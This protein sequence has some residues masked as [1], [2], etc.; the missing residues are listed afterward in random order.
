MKN[1]CRPVLLPLFGL[2]TALGALSAADIEIDADA[3]VLRIDGVDAGGDFRGTPYIATT[4]NGLTRFLFA[5]DLVFEPDDVVTGTGSFALSLT[6]SGD[7]VIPAGAEIDVSALPDRPGPGGGSGGTYGMGG[8]GGTGGSGGS[9]GAGGTGGGGGTSGWTPGQPQAGGDGNLGNNG[10][11]GAS[12]KPGE[13]GAGGRDGFNA[14]HSG[15][16][17]NF[18]D[19][20]NNGGSGGTSITSHTGRGGAR[21]VSRFA[22]PDPGGAG[23]SGWVFFT[24]GDGSDAV[25][26]GW[27]PGGSGGTVRRAVPELTGGGGGAGGQGGSGGAGGGGAGGGASGGGGGGG[28]ADCCTNGTRGTNGQA[29]GNGGKGGNGGSGGRGGLGGSGGGALEIHALGKMTVGGWLGARGGAGEVPQSGGA[30]AGGSTVSYTSATQPNSGSGGFRGGNGGSGA[31][32]GTGGSGGRGGR[33]GAGGGGAGGTIL[34]AATIMDTAGATVDVSGGPAGATG[35]WGS[36]GESGRLV[37]LSETAFSGSLESTMDPEPFPARGDFNPHLSLQS[38]TP[39]LPVFVGGAAIAGLVNGVNLGNFSDVLAEAPA[40]ARMALVRRSAGQGMD[41]PT[42]PHHEFIFLINLTGEA[43]PKPHFGI[44]VPGYLSPLVDGGLLRNPAFGGNGPVVRGELPPYGVYA[45]LVP[46]AD[47]D[48]ETYFTLGYIPEGTLVSFTGE[49]P[50][51]EGTLYLSHGTTSALGEIP[52]AEVVPT[53][54]PSLPAGAGPVVNFDLHGSLQVELEPGVDEDHPDYLLLKNELLAA[55]AGWSLVGVSPVYPSGFTATRLETGLRRITFTRVPGWLPP[56]DRDIAIGPALDPVETR[57]FR[58]TKAPAYEIGSMAPQPVYPGRTLGFWLPAGSTATIVEGNAA[59]A[60]VMLP[61]GWF[62]YDPAATDRQ[63]FSVEFSGPGGTQTVKI[64][65]LKDIPAEQTIIALQPSGA[66]PPDPAGRDFTLLHE[67]AGATSV[68]F[69]PVN[70]TRRVTI[71]G[72]KVVFSSSGDTRLY[73]AVHARDNVEALNIYADEVVIEDPLELRQTEV[74]IFARVL[75][76]KDTG[77]GTAALITTPRQHTAGDGG[78]PLPGGDV[79]LFVPTIVSDPTGSARIDTSGGNT[80]TSQT[81][82]D[83]GLIRSFFAGEMA[84]FAA[85]GGGT[86]NGSPGSARTPETLDTESMPPAYAWLHPMGVRQTILYARNLYYLGFMSEAT[87]LLR[88]YDGYLLKLAEFPEPTLLPDADHPRLQF[89][90]LHRDLAGL[91]TRLDNKLDYFGNSAGWV[92]LLSFEANFQL[93]ESAIGRAMRTLYLHHWLSNSGDFLTGKIDALRTARKEMGAENDRLRNEWPL[94]KEEID[95]LGIEADALELRINSLHDDLRAIE[96]RLEQK[97]AEIIEDRDNI[98][99]WKK[100][101]RTAAALSQTIPA[102]QPALGVAGS[103]LDLASRVDEQDPLDTVLEGTIIAIQFKAAQYQMAAA[104][105][106]DEINASTKSEEELDRDELFDKA[107]QLN[108]TAVAVDESSRTLRQ[109]FASNEAPEDE[110]DSEIAKLRAADPQLRKIAGEL[111]DILQ[112]KQLFAARII[113]LEERLLEIPSIIQKNRLAM[114]QIETSIDDGNGILDPQAFAVV[115]EASARAKDRLRRY[116]YQLAKSFEYRLLKPYRAEGDQAYDPVSVF[117]KI[118]DILEAAEAGGT[119]DVQAGQPHVLSATGFQ[120]L[121]A[122]FEEELAKLVDRIVDEYESGAGVEQVSPNLQINLSGRQLEGLHSDSG[123]RL[124]LHRDLFLQ[125]DNEAQRIADLRVKS[126]GFQLYRDGQPVDPATLNLSNAVVDIR[127]QHSGRSLLR[128]NGQTYAFNH[129][130]GN[131]PERSP[132]TWTGTL[133]LLT[134]EINTVRPSLAT[135]SLLATILGT[136]GALNFNNFSRPAAWADLRIR[137][138]N[139][140]LVPAGGGFLIGDFKVEVDEIQLEMDIDFFSKGVGREIDVRVLELEDGLGIPSELTTRFLF[141]TTSGQPL[142]DR[143]GR[144]D[145]RGSVVRSF[146]STVGE[147]VLSAEPFFGSPLTNEEEAYTGYAFRFWIVSG[148]PPVLTP[149]LTLANTGYRRV[150]AVYERVGDQ[151]PPEISE[152]VQNAPAPFPGEAIFEATFSE[153]VA[154]VLPEQF[155]VN[156]GPYGARILEVT[157][158]GATRSVRV[159]TSGLGDTLWLSF[160]SDGNVVDRAGNSLEGVGGDEEFDTLFE[161]V[162]RLAT[163]RVVEQTPDV[164]R[165]HME[166]NGVQTYRIEYSEDMVEWSPLTEVTLENEVIEIDDTPMAP[167]E[168]RFYRAAFQ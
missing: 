91:L 142:V 39:Y 107:N 26:L 165:L 15:G 29:G 5:G 58:Y 49:S 112:E 19:W 127:I 34:L 81:A 111:T 110:I 96:K 9:G 55:G 10:G 100:S 113:A 7:V 21:G 16:L 149:T 104:E 103:G 32:G 64:T 48:E 83:A 42:L 53:P 63:T 80:T 17:T 145:G 161:T 43:I 166:A 164:V 109:F 118:Q 3:G 92:P 85:F 66:I 36:P 106:D 93:T 40:N 77:N 151:I 157:G 150:F 89:A 52:S 37:V 138:R 71:A 47:L 1:I 122:V 134:G 20:V 136:S 153:D 87:A 163:L 54:V 51:E 72:R 38:E 115:E 67:G 31:P 65:P 2:F 117:E 75:R 4:Y 140:N 13:P 28:G 74:T 139:L 158:T 60:L 146:E 79:H 18:S 88:E 98:P 137:A 35:G 69:T 90:E 56:P 168:A 33:G 121:A 156:G 14:P 133:N 68:N 120:S 102:F 94:V 22:Y 154:G 159:D 99:F 45:T 141:D 61:S 116:F 147:V 131:D 30:G 167:G 25:D 23:G 97:A 24:G 160:R 11:A 70:Q 73:D 128:R 114:L 57:R 41:L 8:D 86:G 135:E 119:P 12:G 125:P 144:G 130:R 132:I 84:V 124:N 95:L 152:V 27:Y 162:L 50:A 105:I 126:V 6:V 108:Q 148:S 82:G 76:F 155:S 101:L 78:S 129:F 44:G 143:V 59:G 123:A 46:K 62:S